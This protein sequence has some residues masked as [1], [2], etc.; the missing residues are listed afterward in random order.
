MYLASCAQNKNLRGDKFGVML[1]HPT[2]TE[3][4]ALGAMIKG[5]LRTFECTFFA[6]CKHDGRTYVSYKT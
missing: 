3:K 2:R 6:R 4:R 5:Q 1:R